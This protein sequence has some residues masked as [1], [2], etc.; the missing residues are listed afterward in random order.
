[1][2]FSPMRA[3]Y[4]VLPSAQRPRWCAKGR[5]EPRNAGARRRQFVCTKGSSSCPGGR[6][7]ERAIDGGSPSFVYDLR[8]GNHC[9]DAFY[10]EVRSFCDELLARVERRFGVVIDGY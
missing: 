1:M 2:N 7:V 6:D 5:K 8:R 4:A 9:S 10:A 3:Y